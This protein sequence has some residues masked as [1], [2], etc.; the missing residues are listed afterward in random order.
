MVASICFDMP[1]L[2][3]IKKYSNRRLYD[4]A[5]SCYIT[6][7]EVREI[8]L[9]QE[10]IVVLDA[11]SGEDIT[12]QILL[13]I[14]SDQ[15]LGGQPML[16]KELLIQMIRFSGGAFQNVFTDYM[17]KAMQMVVD[18]QQAYQRQMTEMMN[19]NLMNEMGD[20]AMR[21]MKL[22]NEMQQQFLKSYGLQP[23]K[24]EK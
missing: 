2:R 14:V 5:N 4:T 6:L 16:T 21:N 15:E 13:Q 3:T 20:M 11:E 10:D 1:T 23:R 19:S 12:R 17:E 18:Q 9:N 24:D 7:S 22:V 8:V